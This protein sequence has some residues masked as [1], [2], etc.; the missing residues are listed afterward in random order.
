[1]DIKTKEKLDYYKTLNAACIALGEGEHTWGEILEYFEKLDKTG[2]L[3]DEE[4]KVYNQLKK[5]IKKTLFCTTKKFLLR[6]I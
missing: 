6:V 3:D 1:M 4:R 5:I 2:N